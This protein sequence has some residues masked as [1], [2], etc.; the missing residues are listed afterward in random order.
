VHKL[1]YLRLRNIRCFRDTKIPI[2]PKLTVIVGPNN[3][4]KSTVLAALATFM[5]QE[6]V[7]NGTREL[8]QSSNCRHGTDFAQFTVGLRGTASGPLPEGI[9]SSILAAL[10]RPMRPVFE[11]WSTSKEVLLEVVHG[12]YEDEDGHFRLLGTD[13]AEALGFRVAAWSRL[14]NGEELS[15]ANGGAKEMLQ[16]L[17]AFLR[18][19][20]KTSAV[21][22][23]SHEE[24]LPEA[25]E[26]KY[27]RRQLHGDDEEGVKAALTFL[28]MRYDSEFRRLRKNFLAT[29]PEFR[30]LEFQ[31]QFARN[32]G[33]PFEFRPALALAEDKEESEVT[34]E[35]IGRGAWAYLSILT[36]ARIAK[37]LRTRTLIL[38]EPHLYLHPGIER[39]L[40]AH[41]Q[42]PEAWDHE[43]LQLIVSTHSPT[44]LDY[45]FRNGSVV[46]LDW[47]DDT[48]TEVVAESLNSDQWPRDLISSPS[49]LFYGGQTIF[50]EGVSDRAAVSL[51]IRELGLRN[52][53]FR[54]EPI[55]L[56]DKLIDNLELIPLLGR[57]RKGGFTPKPILVLDA[58]KKAVAERKWGKT[59]VG[60]D[61]KRNFSVV[62]LGR[63][64]NDFESAFCEVEFLVA[65]FQSRQEPS[66]DCAPLTREKIKARL[67]AIP[68]RNEGRGLMRRQLKGC[69]AVS[70]L[71]ETAG[72]TESR[73]EGYL[74]HLVKFY[75]ENRSKDYCQRVATNL[76]ELTAA[77]RA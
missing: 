40:I 68:A 23:W 49:D 11:P 12:Q 29:F 66:P 17:R 13:P 14:S 52:D 30:S 47:V 54:I 75:L 73:K 19:W 44:L 60:E 69:T 39:A 41:L 58:D 27:N 74:L 62:F 51:L 32:K 45:A 28:K 53:E 34:R 38:D 59:A 3:A 21:T 6:R 7:P 10:P 18:E 1:E 24:V 67:D 16:P 25:V 36:A 33:G 22:H 8:W 77:L 2:H 64:D 76:E 46:I 9:A 48:R 4:G 65:Y 15:K 55:N 57:S 42:D 31:D 37:C 50:V 26:K 70:E 20:R 61:P 63:E 71:H 35:Q 72:L 5:G 56:T 43:P